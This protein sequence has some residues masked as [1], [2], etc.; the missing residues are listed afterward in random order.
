MTFRV[1]MKQAGLGA[2]IV[3]YLATSAS[4]WAQGSVKVRK[5]VRGPDVEGEATSAAKPSK[6]EE[7]EVPE[8]PVPETTKADADSAVAA[9]F[10]KLS[11]V[12]V[13]GKSHKDDI[14]ALKIFYGNRSGAG[15]WVTND[16]FNAKAKAVINEIKN[17]DEWGLEASAFDLPE[18]LAAQSAADVQGAAE[19][20]LS[21]AA[22]KYARYAAGGRVDPQSLSRILDLTPPVRDPSTVIEALAIRE[23]TDSYLRGLHPKHEPFKNL[24][25]ALA[26]ARGPVV[27]DEPVDPALLVKLPSG[28]SMKPGADHPDVALLRKRLKVPAD[29]GALETLFDP[30]LADAVKVYQK[31]KG[32]KADG[33]LNQ[34]TRNALN[35]EGEV[36]KPEPQQVI[37]RIILNMERWRWMPEDM[38]SFYVWNNI[39]EYVTRIMKNGSEIH[40]ERI[41]VGQPSW[42]TPSF[43]AKME[44]VIFHP[45]WGMPD[46]IKM[47]ELLPRIQNSGGGFFDQLFGGGGGS[48][49]RAYGLR[50]SYR[51]RIV[52]P[53]S[54]NW[55]NADLR[56]YSFVQPAGAKNP[57]G[58][59]K[60]RFPNKHDVYMHDTPE[61]ELFS[62]SSRALSHGCIRVNNPK[63]FANILLAEDRGWSE[64]RVDQA[65]A[66]GESITLEK[67]MPV[68]ITYFTVAADAD[69][70]L[71]SYGD[72]YGHDSRL[73]AAL[74]GKAI[75]FNT[76]RDAPSDDVAIS[77]EDISGSATSG[78]SG[79]KKKS[80]KSEDSVADILENVFLN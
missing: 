44:F 9:A 76:P 56:N 58:I 15:L 23:E 12:T 4:V 39:P 8:V 52:D 63:R 29:T 62:R 38:G 50:V 42:P 46:G 57:L 51:G 80:K 79:K 26:K 77:G 32:L 53:D 71:S 21:L 59:V 30:K 78:T 5:V 69:G 65:L 37:Q 3:I 20:K 55:S 10:A 33:V 43:S 17:A 60:F 36:K 28:K 35:A 19:V 34:Q 40:K 67:P 14:R 18:E 74:T 41:I 6:K 72:V 1:L 31:E 25:V 2:V 16:G 7:P 66:G 64:G 13:T 27:K 75:Y 68:H 70:K 24:K 22:L 45:E 73:S 47:K 48:V 49:I 11:D 61:R 54:I